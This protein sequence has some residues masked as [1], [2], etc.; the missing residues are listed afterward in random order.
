M[1]DH[2]RTG[3]RESAGG[4]GGATGGQQA[5]PVASEP[6]AFHKVSVRHE[7]LPAAKK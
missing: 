6:P 2:D 7:K 4:I 3:V 5:G 1:E